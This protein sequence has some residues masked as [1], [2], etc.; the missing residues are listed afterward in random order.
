MRLVAA[1]LVAALVPPTAPVQVML[2][3]AVYAP[4]LV[5]HVQVRAGQDGYLLVLHADPE[6]RV[7]V[8]FPLDPDMPTQVHAGQAI[9]ITTRRGRAAFTVEDTVGSGL[10]YA[11]I[12]TVQFRPDS[13]ALGN[14]WDYRRFPTLAEDQDWNAALTRLV[15]ALA[16]GRFDHD[17]ATYRVVPVPTPSKKPR[18]SAPSGPYA[19]PRYPGVRL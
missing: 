12:S 5:G 4:G 9:D 3:R 6:G 10:W 16:E 8:A 1:L 2:D 17:I 7:R 11:A 13:F 14:H 18:T 19:T 15:S